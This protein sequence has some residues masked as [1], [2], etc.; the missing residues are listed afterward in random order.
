MRFIPRTPEEKADMLRALGVQGFEDLL[1]DIPEDLRLA[2]EL[3]LPLG[4]SEIEAKS[5]LRELA[6]LNSSSER[7]VCFAGAGAYDHYVPSIVD[8]VVSRSEFYTAYT[9]YQA[10]ISQGTLQS[11]YEFQ[12]LITRLTGMEIANASLYDGGTA[13]AEAVLMAHGVN[14]RKQ[15]VVSGCIHPLRLA[16]LNS[17]VRPSGFQVRVADRDEGW[18]DPEKVRSL[19]DGDTCCVIL[20][21]PN[22]FGIVEDPVPI[23]E[24]ARENGALFVVSVDPVSLGLLAPPSGYGADIVVGEGQSLGTRLAFG[25]PYLGFMATKRQYIRK[26]PGRIVG[27]TVD[28]SGRACFCLT[29]QTREQHIRRDKATSNICTNQ[30]LVALRAAVYLSW[31]GPQGIRE[32]A[33][34]CLSKAAYAQG[35]FSEH[36]LMPRF[37]RPCFREFVLDLKCDADQLVRRLAEH[38]ILAGVPL[39]RF[40]EEESGSLLVAFTEKRTR[41]EIDRFASV[42]RGT[43][44]TMEAGR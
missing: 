32:V 31:L 14:G 38:G 8:H 44:E 39:S 37:D 28:G 30:A 9:P 29:L 27:R 7:L 12:S 26:L 5:R 6:R 22:F 20:E 21:N 36:G 16:V 23:G 34:R 18:T 40:Y 25:G 24:L 43:L 13:L 33:H 10:E 41:E 42:A 1:A 17:Y 4:V 11:I 2:G 35:L 15:V 19:V 3:D